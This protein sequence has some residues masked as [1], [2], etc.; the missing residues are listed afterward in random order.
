MAL[1]TIN[2]NA[3]ADPSGIKVG[4]FIISKAQRAAS[5]K[6][7]M[8]IVARKRS[9]ELEW[10]KIATTDLDTILDELDTATFHTVAF[11]DPQGAGGTLTIT[12]YVG[13]IAYNRWYSVGGVAYWSDV[14][15]ALIEQ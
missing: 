4:K 13:D 1:V 9:V 15:I 7:N 11:P 3:I 8:E 6:M 14:R 12:A 2:G 5:G 10:Q